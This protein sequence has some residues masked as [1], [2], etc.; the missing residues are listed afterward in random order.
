MSEGEKLYHE[1]GVSLPETPPPGTAPPPWAATAVVGQ[2]L[3]R[4]DGYERLS[5]AAVFP[6]DLLLPGTIYGALLRCPY[7]HARLL[8]LDLEAAAAM[9]GVRAVIHGG[10][11]E[12]AAVRYDYG[13]RQDLRLFP[14]ECLYE[15]EAVAAV[16]ADTPHQARDALR[17]LA[18]RWETL[19]CVVDHRDARRDGAVAVHPA[20]NRVGE[21]RV[22]ARGDVA[23]GFAAAD[24]VLERDY[25]TPCELHT[26]M[27]LHGCVAA[28]DGPNLT[29]WESTQGVFA[30][31]EQLA[32][33][34]DL[35]LSRVRV[36]GHYVGGGFGSKLQTDKYAVCAALLAARAARPV[37][38]FL[39]R[40][41]TMLAVGNRPAN[42]MR[43][44][45]GVKR[46]GTLTALEL[47]GEGSGGVYGGG[48][49]LLEWEVCDLYAC[50]NVRAELTD[51]AI[52][53]GVQRP[54]RAP[55]HPQ[56]AWALEQM[57][58]EL[59]A[60]IGMDAV[61]LRLRNVPE[62][63]QGRPG[64]PPYTSTGLARCLREGAEAFGWRDALARAAGQDPA[65]PVR[66]GAGMAAGHWVAG[67][68][69]PPA[70][71]V[72][73]VYSDG[74]VVLEMGAADL[75]TGTKTVMAQ[76]VA[77]ELGVRPQIIRVLN[78]DTASCPYSGPSGGSK[79]VPSDGPAVRDAAVKAKQLLL[80]MAAEELG[81]R[82]GDLI[83]AGAVI[84]QRDDPSRQVAIVELPALR[85]RRSVVGVGQ[86][87]PNPEGKVTCPF[88]AQFCEVEVDTRTGEAR[89]LRFL[90]AHDSGRVLNLKTYANQVIG[91][92]TMGIGFGLTEE[93]LLDR[94]QT[95]KLCSKSWHDY[96]LP[97]ALDV[98]ADIATL[99]IE[100]Q[101]DACNTIGAKGLG[102]PVTI[103]TAPAIANAIHAACGVRLREAPVTPLRLAAA[104]AARRQEG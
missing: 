64:A 42:T 87:G 96:K 38:I 21:P 18:P 23:A 73:T 80:E 55:G 1:R 100:P 46:D 22:H 79:T 93:R 67:G 36:V 19:P 3:P 58:D 40:E 41:E 16:A 53:A 52:H 74:S 99:P 86:R 103:P 5:G 77:E 85:R 29:V 90:C 2:A 35:P 9:P 13:S 95:G 54:F 82:P 11:P 39:T 43:L 48:T 47:H 75:G 26:P 68:G 59:A 6:S 15:G 78:A 12:A 63:S 70:G 98:P 4:V 31:Q 28:W 51:W 37:K 88:A 34:L 25:S 32:R 94:G 72:V 30:V 56:G 89:V 50:P 10:T 81:A 92:V 45:A 102:E 44:K 71:A 97:T 57:M 65:S 91:G 62:V 83:Y 104:L 60:A 66:R 84:H 24:V 7:P 27:E 17:A 20:G 33:Y 8:G 49:G 14:E 69:G 76:I 61:E 101:D